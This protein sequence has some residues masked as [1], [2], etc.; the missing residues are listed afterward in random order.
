M[1]VCIR[2][3]RRLVNCLFAP[4]LPFSLAPFLL[5][6]LPPSL[7]FSLPP[8]HPPSLPSP[9][10]PSLPSPFLPP[11]P[12]PSV[13]PYLFA[14]AF[15]APS[16]TEPPRLSHVP[17]SSFPPYRV[18]VHLLPSARHDQDITFLITSLIISNRVPDRRQRHVRPSPSVTLSVHYALYTMPITPP[19]LRCTGHQDAGAHR[20]ASRPELPRHDRPGTTLK[21]R[22]A[23]RRA[24]G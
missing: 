18:P 16:S 22:T 19:P 8:F 13:P 3:P 17:T 11:F 21:T 7:P 6:S 9:L 20:S 10:P 5:L 15:L 24:A 4:S 2:N 23:R 1:R 14:A 12:S